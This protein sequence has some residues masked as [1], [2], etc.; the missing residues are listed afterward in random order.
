MR[1]Q[2]SNGTTVEDAPKAILSHPDHK[3]RFKDSSVVESD[4]INL[5]DSEKGFYEFASR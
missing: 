3:G 5:G 1:T 2:I 4:R